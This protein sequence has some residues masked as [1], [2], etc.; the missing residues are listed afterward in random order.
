MVWPLFF[1]LAS[2][3]PNMILYSFGG[4]ILLTLLGGVWYNYIEK[5]K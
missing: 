5:G 1:G 4:V 2:D 3:S